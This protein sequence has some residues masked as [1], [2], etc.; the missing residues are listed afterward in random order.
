MEGSL[1][2]FINLPVQRPF[3]QKLFSHSC[4]VL[5]G[6]PLGL[7]LKGE[8]KIFRINMYVLVKNIT[9]LNDL[10]IIKDCKASY[11]GKIVAY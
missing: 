3:S 5:H 9:L 11:R 8:G 6:L 2:H 4:Q 10:S 7:P 1:N